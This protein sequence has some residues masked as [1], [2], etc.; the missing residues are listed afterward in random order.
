[1][2]T[3]QDDILRLQYN[4][5]Q[6]EYDS[7]VHSFEQLRNRHEQ[8]QSIVDNLNSSIAQK[9]ARICDLETQLRSALAREHIDCG[10]NAVQS[11]FRDALREA[12]GRI[13]RLEQ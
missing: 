11:G 12:A 8:S 7:L 10:S 9:E 6:Q 3:Y 1:M 13:R 2:Y 5:L 4:T